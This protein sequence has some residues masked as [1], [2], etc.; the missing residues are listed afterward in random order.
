MSHKGGWTSSCER[1]AATE[2]LKAG[3]QAT[4]S[5]LGCSRDGKRD[6]IRRQC[7]AA[8][9]R[10]SHDRADGCGNWIWMGEGKEH[11]RKEQDVED[12]DY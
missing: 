3:G 8:A 7:L 9:G 10:K 12:L 5:E 4:A 2:G 6:E 11:D 1:R